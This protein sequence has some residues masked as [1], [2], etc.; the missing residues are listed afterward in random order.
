M[1]DRSNNPR[2]LQKR[3]FLS[4]E[5]S[6]PCRRWREPGKPEFFKPCF[7][8]QVLAVAEAQYD[9][10]PPR[11]PPP[12]RM[13]LG[14]QGLLLKSYLQ[15]VFVFSLFFHELN[16]NVELGVTVVLLL[17][18]LIQV[19]EDIRKEHCYRP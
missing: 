4:I 14:S 5:L 19:F 6:R 11:P 8:F 1:R 2:P 9:G 7:R 18:C 13:L 17:R 15:F 12:Q 16:L 10:R 3:R